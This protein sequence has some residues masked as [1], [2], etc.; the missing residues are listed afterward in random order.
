MQQP[1]IEDPRLNLPVPEY[2]AFSDDD[3]RA[4]GLKVGLEIHQQLLTRRKL[5][6]RCPAG[7]YDCHHHDA[8][9]LRHMRPTLSEMGE[10]DGTA[11]MEFKTKKQIIYQ[12]KSESVCTYEM[13]D[14]PPFELDPEALDCALAI[15]RLLNLKCV[16]EL[17]IAR[18]QYLDGSIP[19]GFQ[20][21]TIVGIDGEIPFATES[22]P[23]R[24]IHI[25][26]L[27]LE[28]DSC[29]EVSDHGHTRVYRTDRLGMPLI[30]TVT[31]PNM[32]T[33]EEAA[34][35][36][37]QLR[38]LVRLTHLVRTGAGAARQDVNV[39]ITGGTRIEIKGVPS[40]KAIPRLVHSEALRQR[41]LLALAEVLRERGV[42]EDQ[43]KDR[44]QNVTSILRN[45][46]CL[47]IRQAILQGAQVKAIALP[48]F[49]GL[50]EVK[51]QPHTLFLKEFSDRIRVIACIDTLPNV[52]A[53][54]TLGSGISSAEWSK[55]AHL[56]QAGAHTPILL[57]W[58]RADDVET[59][60][61]EVMIR[62][63]EALKGVPEETRQ[64]LKD[65]TT[66]FERILPGPERMYPDTDLPPIAIDPARIKRVTENLPTPP[67]ER[68]RYAR[69][70]HV[71]EN[72]A[73][74]LSRS[75]AFD[76]FRALCDQ[77]PSLSATKI[78]SLLLDRPCSGA[79]DLDHLILWVGRLQRVA[80][81][82]IHFEA[83]W[84]FS[85]AECPKAEQPSNEIIALS[86]QM[87]AHRF[88]PNSADPEAR[89]RYWM[90]ELMPQNRGKYEGRAM[91]EA[92][93]TAVLGD[94][95]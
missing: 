32:H 3:Y 6:C 29:R 40:I 1:H 72:L 52:I 56:V 15:A 61:K 13:D 93:R 91:A 88:G 8:E 43:L 45:T 47:F 80:L 23:D 73:E 42:T 31:G 71:T 68:M 38:Y 55:I 53:S 64:A 59:A 9:I 89:M 87:I 58:G 65:G 21:T 66:G 12:L 16:D 14:A 74:R 4:L 5:F 62:A 67:W 49:D 81:G 75:P 94:A 26:Q 22:D 44:S 27:G 18:K 85:D 95:Q 57:V 69:E 28:E 60:C 46:D 17:H 24:K 83:L 79:R 2:G 39:S 36:A 10:Y 54:T 82:E 7:L 20:R 90:G 76:L 34:A 35:V 92:I 41:T 19:T 37:N 78:A 33:P 63:R 30:E 86:R 51:T 84:Q 11:L 70:H 50:L 25:R 48:G 77:F